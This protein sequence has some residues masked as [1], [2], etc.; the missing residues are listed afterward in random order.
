MPK[1]RQNKPHKPDVF[2]LTLIILMVA[3]IV[4]IAN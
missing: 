2:E 3:F 4:W 1:K